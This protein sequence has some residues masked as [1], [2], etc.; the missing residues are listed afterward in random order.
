[1]NKRKIVTYAFSFLFLFLCLASILNVSADNPELILSTDKEIYEIGEEVK[2]S[3]KLENAKNITFE[4]DNPNEDI[5]LILTKNT[6]DGKAKLIFNLS[7]NAT[8]GEYKVIAIGKTPTEI[9]KSSITF[10]VVK[11]IPLLP[12]LKITNKDI[13]FSNKNPK[14]G[15]KIRIY[16]TIHN[17][18]ENDSKA[19]VKFF[20]GAPKKGGIQIDKNQPISVVKGKT[21]DVFVDWIAKPSGIHEIYVMIENSTPKESDITNNIANKPI[22]VEKIPKIP[23]LT[24]N[25]FDIS[26]LGTPKVKETVKILAAIHNLGD[27]K[28]LATVKIFDGKPK[29]DESNLIGFSKI[30]VDGKGNYTVTED[31]TPLKKGNHTIYVIIE[32][33]EPKESNI[34]NNQAK[35]TVYVELEDRKEKSIISPIIVG[36]AI[37]LVAIGAFFFV[38]TEIGV[39]GLLTTLI[40]PLYN[41]LSK[42][43]LEN[44]QIRYEII[45]FLKANPGATFTEI[46]KKLGLKN[47][48]AAH[49]LDKLEKGN[50]IK[51]V[52]Q[53]KY[54]RFYPIPM[55][56]QN[57]ERILDIIRENPGITQNEISKL[58]KISQ[59]LV[60]Y[61]LKLI[62]R[63]G[64]VKMEKKGHKKAYTVIEIEEKP[65]RN[66][67]FCGEDFKMEKTPKFCPYCKEEL[68]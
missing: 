11:K 17:I 43:D 24:L 61:H 48:S 31:W 25:D 29:K 28:G 57:A 59:P 22:E 30:S 33:C 32:N 54:K 45:G 46:K 18:G 19:L 10:E 21:D 64:N 52:R 53:G 44:Q 3:A 40:L 50:I 35:K 2:I 9:V 67:P 58:T 7:E 27:I 60:S 15:E 26:I 68:K 39:Y 49:H 42:E 51:S 12:D 63:D 20:D 4:I 38:G 36:T 55:I 62:V 8:I 34:K 1:M 23:D 65:F 56:P 37:G 16:A 5:L 13:K 14:V 47:G 66:C 6:T 41:K